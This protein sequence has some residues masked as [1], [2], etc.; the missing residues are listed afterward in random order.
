MDIG[1]VLAFIVFGDHLIL[2]TG[3]GDSGHISCISGSCRIGITAH[4]IIVAGDHNVFQFFRCCRTTLGHGCFF[5]FIA[6]AYNSVTVPFQVVAVAENTGIDSS[7]S[8]GSS[9]RII[10]SRSQDIGILAF[11]IV[12]SPNSAGRCTFR[13][14]CRAD[15]K[16]ICIQGLCRIPHGCRTL[17]VALGIAAD[18]DGFVIRNTGRITNGNRFIYTASTIFYRRRRKSPYSQ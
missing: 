12:I 17:A 7:Y 14:S 18:S 15:S 9:T 4:H 13:L 16:G 2:G 3:H 8:I 1:K 5:Y 11:Y 10:I 6:V